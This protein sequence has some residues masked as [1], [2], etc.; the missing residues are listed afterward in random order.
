MAVFLI[1]FGDIRPEIA[2][3]H[4]TLWTV[5]LDLAPENLSPLRF[6]TAFSCA[7]ATFFYEIG[8]M[9]KRRSVEPPSAF[10]MMVVFARTR[11]AIL[12]RVIEM[13]L[14]LILAKNV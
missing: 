6:Q 10:D 1:R 12:R 2:A 5:P 4:K 7:A 9:E 11:K 14:F 8:G 3:A 13:K